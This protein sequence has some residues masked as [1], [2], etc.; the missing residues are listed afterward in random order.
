M[1][2]NQTNEVNTGLLL[3]TWVIK[4]TVCGMETSTLKENVLNIVVSKEGHADSVLEH[5]ASLLIFLK[6][7]QL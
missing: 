5:D 7:V 6:K 3:Q 4:K 1:K 2:P